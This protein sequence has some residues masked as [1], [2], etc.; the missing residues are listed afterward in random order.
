MPRL[1]VAPVGP[2]ARG[3]R[4][5][6]KWVAKLRLAIS[7]NTIATASISGESK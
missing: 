1:G 4:Q 6:T 7:M 3:A 2:Q 5:T